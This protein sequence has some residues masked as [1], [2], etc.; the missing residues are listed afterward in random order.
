MFEIDLS[1]LLAKIEYLGSQNPF[2]IS[3]YIF[4]HGGWIVFVIFFLWAAHEMWLEYVQNKFMAKQTYVH[5]SVSV[6]KMNEQSPKAVENVFSHLAGAH[7]SVNVY[8]KYVEGQKQPYFSMEIIST[9]GYIQFI[10]RTNTKFRDLVEASIF[11]QYPDAE[12]AEVPDYTEGFSTKFPNDEYDLWGTEFIITEKECYPLR[13]YKEF[14]H[15]LTGEFK[16]PM[17]AL[18][19]NY[20]RIG[21]GEHVWF[22]IIAVPIGQKEWKA[23]GI[24]EVK[25]LIGAETKSKK[26]LTDFISNVPMKIL[27]AAG[28]IVSLEG[29][30]GVTKSKKPE[31]PKEKSQM[32]YMSP[33]E[34]DVVAGIELKLS[35]IGFRCKIRAIYVAKKEVFQKSRAA[36][37]LIGAMKQFNTVNLNSIKPDYKKVGTG[38]IILFKKTRLNYRRGKILRAYKSRSDWAGMGTG[39]VLNIE[40]L[41][42]LYHFPDISVK[43]PLL[44][45]TEAKRGE[46]P[47]A[48]PM[49]IEKQIVSSSEEARDEDEGEIPD[50]L[51]IE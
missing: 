24:A 18:L 28:D 10:V 8:D 44:K 36:H 43:A 1:G 50:N 13:S 49:E 46:P 6:P 7:G 16:D 14:E 42:T 34:K 33:G 35:K 11:A 21:R 25:K 19:E 2:V 3:W 27:E 51:P 26:G 20:S 23:R 38:G 31:K 29:E 17:A 39:F 5:L 22:Q 41:A 30:S 47:F 4:L 12:I 37:P 15:P 48:L 40:E 45:K 32:L 9:E